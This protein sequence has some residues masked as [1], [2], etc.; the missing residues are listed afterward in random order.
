MFNEYT[1]KGCLF[2]CRL[3]KA[4]Q[5]VGCIPWDYPLPPSII[6]DQV[7]EVSICNASPGGNLTEFE[8]FMDSAESIDGC[9]C[10]PDCDE[11]T[12]EYQV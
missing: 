1:H 9:E 5:I 2:E 6:K 4:F 12:F 8:T 10:E 3:T 11:V 7:E